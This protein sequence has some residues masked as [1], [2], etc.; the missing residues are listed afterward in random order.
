MTPRRRGFAGYAS[1]GGR[2]LAS[3]GRNFGHA[4]DRFFAN[5]RIG[6]GVEIE[7]EQFACVFILGNHGH[8]G[9]IRAIVFGGFPGDCYRNN[10]VNNRRQPSG[11]RSKP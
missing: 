6:A 9:A 8:S 7:G 1:C 11:T 4:V 3:G 2:L 10:F 5:Q